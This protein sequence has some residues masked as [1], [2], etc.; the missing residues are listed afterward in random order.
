MANAT[1]YNSVGLYRYMS[2]DSKFYRGLI[3]DIL[4]PKGSLG[5]FMQIR[6]SLEL[7]PNGC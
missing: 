1:F 4:K 7:Y 5:K 6:E 3:E 2:Y